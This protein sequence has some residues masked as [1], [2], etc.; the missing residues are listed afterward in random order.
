MRLALVD[1]NK[2]NISAAKSSFDSGTDVETYEA[3]VSKID[4]WKDLKQKIEKR[5]GGLNFLMLNAGIGAKGTW[6]DTDY[7]YKVS[8]PLN[9]PTIRLT[10]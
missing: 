1:Y 5:F 2:E 9:P 7:F 4:T 8:I 10:A 3:D 6:E